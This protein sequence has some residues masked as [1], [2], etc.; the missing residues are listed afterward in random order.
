MTVP[1][2]N[3]S[4]VRQNFTKQKEKTKITPLDEDHLIEEAPLSVLV[5]TYL[6]YLIVIIFG[7]IRDFFG[8]RFKSME[9]AHLQEANGYA[10]LTSDFDSFYTRRLYTRIRDCWNRPCTGVPGRTITLLERKS[11]DFNRTFSL[12]G[13]EKTVLNFSSYNYLGFAQSEGLCADEVEAITLKDGVGVCSPRF[14]LGTN[15]FHLELEKLVARFVGKEAALVVSMGFATN[16]TTVPA[17]CG[18]GDLIISDEFNHSSLVYG[19]RLSNATI[20]IFKH[21]D[22]ADSSFYRCLGTKGWGCV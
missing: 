1:V 9:Y 13:K 2:N 21:N 18:K 20:R 3:S 17:L 22:I 12:T 7:H 10:P 19:S 5:T 8:K 4:V 16:S 11:K 15:E 6:G 14:E